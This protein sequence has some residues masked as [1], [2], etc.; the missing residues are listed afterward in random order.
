M[1]SDLEHFFGTLAKRCKKDEL[2]LKSITMVQLPDVP[3]PS[4]IPGENS[5]DDSSVHGSPVNA[6][7]MKEN[8]TNGGYTVKK[9]HSYAHNEDDL[10][11]SPHD[12]PFVRS[13]AESPSNEFSTAPF[14]K[15]SEADA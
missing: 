5:F 9:E 13:T 6:N 15:S 14:A 8:F 11:K 1:Q 10:A 2:N 4:F 7:G 3:K 12:S